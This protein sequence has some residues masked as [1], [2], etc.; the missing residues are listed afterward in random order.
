VDKKYSAKI[1]EI[2]ANRLAPFSMIQEIEYI[3]EKGFANNIDDALNVIDK[4]VYLSQA[5]NIIDADVQGKFNDY[6]MTKK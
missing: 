6:L 4:Y 2:T 1:K 5:A 3:I